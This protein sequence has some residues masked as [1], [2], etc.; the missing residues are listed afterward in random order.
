MSGSY[1]GPAALARAAA[2]LNARPSP[3]PRAVL[4]TDPDRTPD[5]AS[6]V[7]ALPPGCAVVF[8]HFGQPDQR[9][10]AGAVAKAVEAGGHTLI[11]AADPELALALDAAG[12]HWPEARLGEAAEWA[13]RFQ[14]MTASAHGASAVLRAE[15]L[16]GAVFLSPVL[17]SGS[18]SA[19]GRA[20]GIEA[21]AAIA[22]GAGVPVYALG[23][24]NART[25]P[26]LIGRG[27]S[28][29]A[30]VEGWSG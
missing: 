24:V 11:V 26:S 5:P 17:A 3:L 13:G 22:R 12:V 21:A 16:V 14:V 23:G 8:R 15:P 4:F 18:P 6:S 2:A 1:D 7:S 20:L 9:A 27:F 28:G 25:A 10:R 30:A 19:A 29:L